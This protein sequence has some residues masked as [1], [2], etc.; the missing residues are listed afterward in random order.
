MT[1]DQQVLAAIVQSVE[2]L[3]AVQST[4]ERIRKPSNEGKSVVA[5]NCSK[6]IHARI[7]VEIAA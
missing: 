6:Y 4:D 1:S 5:P 7:K 3:M 2:N